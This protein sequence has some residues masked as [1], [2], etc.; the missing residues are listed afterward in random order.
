V[1]RMLAEGSIGERGT[2]PQEL[3]V[4][5]GRLAAELAAR[6]VEIARTVFRPDDG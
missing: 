3:A 6:G 4:P 5:A 1:A 2:L